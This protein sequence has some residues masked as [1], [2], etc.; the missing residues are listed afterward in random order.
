MWCRID[1]VR[2]AV[3]GIKRSQLEQGGGRLMVRACVVLVSQLAPGGGVLGGGRGAKGTT[4][5]KRE[6]HKHTHVRTLGVHAGGLNKRQ[7]DCE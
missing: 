6:A 4:A 1:Q 2:E 7:A 5:F 3:R